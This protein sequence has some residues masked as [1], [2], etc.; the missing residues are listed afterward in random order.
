MVSGVIGASFETCLQEAFAEEYDEL[1]C[2][3]FRE[4]TPS[5]CSLEHA[6]ANASKFTRRVERKLG[7]PQLTAQARQRFGVD[8]VEKVC[9]VKDG[10]PDYSDFAIFENTIVPCVTS[11]Y[12][13]ALI[14]SSGK[15]NFSCKADAFRV[16]LKCGDFI[17]SPKEILKDSTE[18]AMK[19]LDTKSK[20]WLFPVDEGEKIISDREKMASEL[21][22]MNAVNMKILTTKKPISVQSITLSC[23][24]EKAMYGDE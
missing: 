11:N 7:F 24:D 19:L 2:R 3:N 18:L 10:V 22:K 12:F 1:G 17:F 5:D 8:L 4:L 23:E 9:I 14:D 15:W 6:I 16:K 21:R 13:L 20:W